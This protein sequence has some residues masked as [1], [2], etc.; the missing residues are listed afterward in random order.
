MLGA[1]VTVHGLLGQELGALDVLDALV[2]AAPAGEGLVH[3][4]FA[5]RVEERQVVAF[6][7]CQVDTERRRLINPHEVR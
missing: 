3:L 6:W 5:R 2:G 4:P 1:E 7:F